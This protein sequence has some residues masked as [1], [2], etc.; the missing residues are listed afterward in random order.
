M[1]L[2]KKAEKKGLT[3]QVSNQTGSCPL[4]QISLLTA[5]GF[6]AMPTMPFVCAHRRVISLASTAIAN[7]DVA[8][9][10]RFLLKTSGA[11][12][13]VGSPKRCITLLRHTTRAAARAP[14]FSSNKV[15][16]KCDTK[17]ALYI[18]S[19]PSA[20]VAGTIP[21]PPMPALS[22]RTS[23]EPISR[24]KLLA[25]AATESKLSR[26]S[27][28]G[29]TMADEDFARMASAAASPFANDRTASI[30]RK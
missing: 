5:P 30:T 3:A 14:F 25:K 20:V 21:I 26:S 17:L 2:R 9:V 16:R 7:L 22:T 1:V 24:R 27:C 29:C 12:Q 23:T 8:Y 10:F 28:I 19:A 18:W 4:Y 13:S 11:R 6:V 15:S